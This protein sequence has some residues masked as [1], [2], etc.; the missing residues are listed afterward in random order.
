ML[1]KMIRECDY[2]SIDL[3][4]STHKHI[5]HSLALAYSCLHTHT[6]THTHTPLPPPP[7]PPSM[8]EMGVVPIDSTYCSAAAGRPHTSSRWDGFSSLRKTLRPPTVTS[9]KGTTRVL[10]RLPSSPLTSPSPSPPLPPLGLPLTATPA[11]GS[12]RVK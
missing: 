3:R 5:T 10:C 2:R 11:E 7:P 12:P 1:R 4:V 6:H 8:S 9:H